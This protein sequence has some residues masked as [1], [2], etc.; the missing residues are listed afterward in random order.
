MINGIVLAG[1]LSSRFGSCKSKLEIDKQSI[2]KNTFNLAAQF[3]EEVAV[4]CREEKKIDGYPHIYD[5]LI[6]YAPIC[7]IYSAL[8]HYKSPVL[9]L[10]CDL[11]FINKETIA[12]LVEERNKAI[13]NNENILM[14]TFR[15]EGTNFIEALVAIYEYE[16][17]HPI[18]K[19]L[20]KERYSLFKAI[21]EEK[22]HHI[23]T[24]DIE[25]FF[26]I[27][28]PKDLDEAKKINNKTK[29]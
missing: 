27:N 8:E 19:A 21:P 15:P 9:V 11:P 18:K 12:T 6:C 23:I 13:Q 5:K 24:Q 4:S 28:Y 22:R 26:N 16:A 1:G 10:S 20:E 25:V 14:T 17:I 7:G 29:I 3:C 2:L